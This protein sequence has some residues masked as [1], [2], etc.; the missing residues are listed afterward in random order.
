MIRL[1]GLLIVAF[2]A[3]PATG[4]DRGPAGMSCAGP[5][6]QGGFVICALSADTGAYQLETS[7]GK[8][9]KLSFGH[10]ALLPFS[11]NSPLDIIV[12]AKGLSQHWQPELETQ[13][14]T[15]QAGDWAIERIDGLP[16]GK[17]TPRTLEQQQKVE[18]DW[19]KKQIAWAHRTAASWY[20]GGFTK[21]VSNS[22][23]SGVYG[24]QR[25]LNGKPKNPH[26]GMD[27]AAPKGT[28]ILSPA[29]AEVV[30]AE[31][32]MYFEGGLLVLDHGA[33][34]MSVMLHMS[35]LDV[36]LGEQV[37]QGQK[38]GEVGM[39][40]RATGPH[41]HWGIKVRGTYISPALA[42]AYTAPQEAIS[43]D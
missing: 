33:G 26:L 22:R 41:L 40:G 37:K 25:I 2:M 35:K 36:K 7:D 34:V 23:T 14:F 27:F 12:Q 42:L 13:R 1:F 28:D 29:Q 4:E 9:A 19:K 8:Q 10:P 16:P 17:V 3:N 11:R 32:D 38:V 39:T 15:L 18:A 5:L 20:A 6:F 21:P 24:S 43:S 31:P 30:L